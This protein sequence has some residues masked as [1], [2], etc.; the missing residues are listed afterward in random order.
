MS[1]FE[2]NSVSSNN[3]KGQW[4]LILECYYVRIEQISYILI[5]FFHLWISFIIYEPF[6]CVTFTCLIIYLF[7]SYFRQQ[8]LNITDY[9]K[10]LADLCKSKNLNIDE[11]KRQMGACGAPGVSTN[12]VSLLLSFSLSPILSDLFS[13]KYK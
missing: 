12:A 11:V 3:W 7:I 1:K 13:H 9:E 5:E 4:N 10:F 2:K 6:F 8:K